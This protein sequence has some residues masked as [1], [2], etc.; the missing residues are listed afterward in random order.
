[1]AQP[2][3]FGSIL[4]NAFF[5]VHRNKSDDGEGAKKDGWNDFG[6]ENGEAA[7]MDRDIG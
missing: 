5:E 7:T 4:K 1:M 3:I 2:E 6:N